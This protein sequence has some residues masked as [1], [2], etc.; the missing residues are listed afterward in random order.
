MREKCFH[1]PRPQVF[2]V[3]LAMKE[4]KAFN[5]SKLCKI[6]RCEYCSVSR[7]ICRDHFLDFFAGCWPPTGSRNV[8]R[9]FDILRSESNVAFERIPLIAFAAAPHLPA[10]MPGSSPF[11]LRR[12]IRHSPAI[13]QAACGGDAQLQSL[14]HT[15]SEHSS[16]VIKH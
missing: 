4:D 5:Y 15:K 7:A 3:P 11:L 9:M 6:A 8:H 10:C 1:I 16:C 13:T 12:Q 2:R 14:C